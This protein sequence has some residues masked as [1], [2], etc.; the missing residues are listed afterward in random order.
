M[1]RLGAASGTDIDHRIEMRTD[2][3]ARITYASPQNSVPL[4]RSLTIRAGADGLPASTLRLTAH[5]AFL[6]PRGWH[7]GPLGP[8]EEVE[9][10]DRSVDLDMVF[11]DALGEAERGELTFTLTDE[12][13]GEPSVL[14]RPVDLLARDQWGGADEMAQTL[15]AF[16]QPNHPAVRG[17][18]RPPAR[19][20]D[21]T[22]CPT[23]WTATRAG[24]RGAPGRS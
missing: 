12:A 16:V 9:V 8:G 10:A 14:R 7:V 1:R 13:G 17:S 15:A 20:C 21:P 4:I 18:S 2:T 5:P 22:A 23:A 3:A 19:P 6:R 24:T 11:L